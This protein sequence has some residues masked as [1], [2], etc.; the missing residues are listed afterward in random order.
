MAE[1]TNGKRTRLAFKFS[2]LALTL[3]FLRG[4]DGFA[5]RETIF[6]FF[7][8]LL[9]FLR[10]FIAVVL[11]GNADPDSLVQMMLSASEWIHFFKVFV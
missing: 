6:Q 2:I 4:S 7:L 11:R 10:E 8:L 9:L 5:F 3:H 1:D